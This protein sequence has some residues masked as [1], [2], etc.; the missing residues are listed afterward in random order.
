MQENTSAKYEG[1]YL[2]RPFNAFGIYP[3]SFDEFKESRIGQI[4]ITDVPSR[5]KEKHFNIWKE[6]LDIDFLTTPLSDS[7]KV[8]K[9]LYRL[10]PHVNAQSGHWQEQTDMHHAFVRLVE[11]WRKFEEILDRWARTEIG[12]HAGA[13]DG[14]F[15]LEEARF[16][17]VLARFFVVL[18]EHG[19]P[20]LWEQVEEFV[21]TSMKLT[22]QI[23]VWLREVGRRG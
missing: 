7:V 10:R 18:K 11:L 20:R 5:I 16:L 17:P 22:E 12:A 9:M 23:E 15:R 21:T 14:L 6:I 19:R 4:P 1:T 3:G 13:A 2:S 8:A